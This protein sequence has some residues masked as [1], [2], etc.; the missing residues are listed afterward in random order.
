[1]VVLK[2]I[3]MILFGCAMA[4]PASADES[5]KSIP[6][7]RNFDLSRYLGTWYEIAR[8]PHRFEK[9]L[10]KVTATY[11][12]LS[13][14]KIRVLNRG[15]KPTKNKWSEAKGKAWIPDPNVA[16]RLRVR[17]FWPF[18]ADYRIIKL[19]PDYRWAVVTSGSKDYL[20]ILSRTPKLDEAVYGSLVQFIRDNGFNLEKLIRVEQE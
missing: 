11:T 16:A 19:D 2:S 5:A 13:D 15:Y 17:F 12:L 8:L 18:S 3:L 20:W 7:V 6:L 9:D 1:M 10:I 4:V 14:G